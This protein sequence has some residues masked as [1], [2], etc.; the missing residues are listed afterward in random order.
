MI[1]ATIQPRKLAGNIT[2]I[3]HG[4]F[5]VLF[6]R[7][8]PVTP[9]NAM[10]CVAPWAGLSPIKCDRRLAAT[11]GL[12]GRPKITNKKRFKKRHGVI[13]CWSLAR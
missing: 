7:S 9:R 8:P 11:G 12:R 4:S 3:I 5:H 6:H 10:L 13:D 1:Q 2:N